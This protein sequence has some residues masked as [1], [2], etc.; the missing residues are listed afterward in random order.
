MLVCRLVGHEWVETV[1]STTLSNGTE[2]W[3]TRQ[4]CDRCGVKTIMFLA[5]IDG[6][7]VW[8]TGAHGESFHLSLV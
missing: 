1:A 3:T 6:E 5:K 4:G 2:M 7:I 8:G